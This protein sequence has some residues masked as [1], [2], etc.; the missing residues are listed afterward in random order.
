M[1]NKEVNE[2]IVAIFL[3]LTLFTLNLLQIATSSNKVYLDANS[4]MLDM[5]MNTIERYVR[6]IAYFF[7]SCW[8]SERPL[9]EVSFMIY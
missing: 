7:V 6:R 5:N 3:N 2:G 9:E 1:S 8:I 4:L